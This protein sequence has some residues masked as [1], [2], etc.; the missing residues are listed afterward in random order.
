M[1]TFNN[2]SEHER[3][4]SDCGMIREMDVNWTKYNGKITEKLFYN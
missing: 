1:C 4:Y 3:L 2:K